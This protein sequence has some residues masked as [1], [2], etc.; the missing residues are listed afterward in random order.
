MASCIFCHIDMS[1]KFN[2]LINFVCLQDTEDMFNFVRSGPNADPM[3]SDS[4]GRRTLGLGLRKRP[5]DEQTIYEYIKKPM[6]SA[7]KIIRIEIH[8]VETFKKVHA[9]SS[10]CNCEAEI[11]VQHITESI[12]FDDIYHAVREVIYKIQSNLET[13]P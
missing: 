13:K 7:Y 11:C 1:I 4:A 5:R 3:L 8:D 6:S 12:L 2:L 9:N 10:I